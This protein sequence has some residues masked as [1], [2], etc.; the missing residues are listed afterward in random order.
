MFNNNNILRMPCRILVKCLLVTAFLSMAVQLRAAPLDVSNPEVLEAYFDGVVKNNMSRAHSPSG[1]VAV[2]KDNQVIFTKGYGYSDFDKKI[3]VDPNT[4]LFRPG[5]ISKLFTW[6]SV[7]QLVE[8]GKLDLDAD[9]NMYLQSFQVK[10]SWPG[11]P[12]TLRHILTHTAGFEDA[13]IGHLIIKDQSRI[14]PLAQALAAY[15]PERINPPGEHVAYSNWATA[16]AGLIVAEVS[17]QNFNDYVQTH[18]FD[19]LGMTHTTFVEPLPK[20]LIDSRAKAYTFSQGTYVETGYELVSNFGP[21]GAA[22][23]TA[24]DMAKFARAI[25]NDGSYQ[26]Q[27]ILKASTVSQMLNEGFVHDQRVRGMGLGFIKYRYG[28]DE[29]EV[30]GH[31]GA[32]MA[33]LSHF[34]LSKSQN[35]MLFTSFSGQPAPGELHKAIVKGFYDEFFPHTTQKSYIEKVDESKYAGSYTSW[36]SNFT[37]LESLLRLASELKVVALADGE[38]LLI[39]GERYKAVDT[40]L[41]EQVNGYGRIAFQQSADGEIT[42]FVIDG[43][44]VQQFFRTPTAASADLTLIIISLILIIFTAVILRMCYQFS[45]FKGMTGV[46]KSGTLASLA[47]AVMNILFFVFLFLSLANGVDDMIFEI[48]MSIKIALWFALLATAAVIIQ[49]LYLF[50]VWQHKAFKNTLARIRYSFVTLSGLYMVWF[51]YYWNLL[52]FNYFE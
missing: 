44:G 7:M 48:P 47:T 27:R 31:D 10:D 5:S 23:T 28:A 46:E 22:A 20:H 50:K 21:A 51:F 35:L 13:A 43:F 2:M 34:G 45:S 12:V 15:Q 39:K 41:F 42:G 38:T 40:N 3:P 8:Q 25:L 49:F 24:T 30:F 33:F 16:L 29:L 11:Q 6:V 9:V 19:V 26:S 14:V 18:I 32:T 37:Q 17:G 4:T 52:G 36:R 1:V